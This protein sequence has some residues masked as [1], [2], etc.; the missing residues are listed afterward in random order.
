MEKYKR[1]KLMP[2]TP[3]LI[4]SVLSIIMGILIFNFSLHVNIILS[5]IFNSIIIVWNI[6][7]LLA[8]KSRNVIQVKE[9]LLNLSKRFDKMQSTLNP[10]MVKIN[11]KINE[12]TN[13]FSR[14]SNELSKMSSLDMRYVDFMD[15]LRNV[16]SREGF[17]DSIYDDDK[18]L[19]N[20]FVFGVNGNEP[21]LTTLANRIKEND[22]FNGIDGVKD[23][24]NIN[25]KILNDDLDRLNA[26]LLNLVKHAINNVKIKTDASSKYLFSK[27]Q[28]DEISLADFNNDNNNTT[29]AND[30]LRENVK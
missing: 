24:I 1:I 28:S 22:S 10:E 8:F 7:N 25:T 12:Y 3:I 27:L 15:K 29:I 14:D 2:N 11:D 20:S 18:E 23:D 5:L 19:L 6:I 13:I 21:Y 16:I 26:F 30:L 4:V 9:D 17:I